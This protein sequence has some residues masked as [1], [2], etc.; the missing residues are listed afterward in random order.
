MVSQWLQVSQ[1]WPASTQPH[2][3]SW[4]ARIKLVHNDTCVPRMPVVVSFNQ[5]CIFTG[6][7]QYESHNSKIMPINSHVISL[8]Q[9]YL[10]AARPHEKR[11]R[12]ES[13]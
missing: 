9:T 4:F 2:I 5:S 1:L 8:S 13:E 6:S 7:Q 12:A 11:E 3:C 10:F